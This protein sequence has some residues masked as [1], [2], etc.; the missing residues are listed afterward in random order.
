MYWV[1]DIRF[2]VRRTD[3]ELIQEQA[4]QPIIQAVKEIRIRSDTELLDLVGA[5]SEIIQ[6]IRLFPRKIYS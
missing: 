1:S 2:Q 5:G 6:R 3:V 4:G